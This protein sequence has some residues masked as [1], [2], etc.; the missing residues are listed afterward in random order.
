MSRP[1]PPNDFQDLNNSKIDFLEKQTMDKSHTYTSFTKISLFLNL[2]AMAFSLFLVIVWFWWLSKINSD[3]LRCADLKKMIIWAIVTYIVGFFTQILGIV[4]GY[5]RLAAG[6]LTYQVVLVILFFL[7][8]AV[9]IKT[10][11][12]SI[13]YLEGC[14]QTKADTSLHYYIYGTIGYCIL[15]MVLFTCNLNLMYSLRKMNKA[16]RIQEEYFM[17]GEKMV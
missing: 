4:A 1:F 3:H 5:M 16:Q 7:R 13:E 6:F 10:I 2:F 12:N 9:D 14:A 17:G 11:N 8:I 15:V